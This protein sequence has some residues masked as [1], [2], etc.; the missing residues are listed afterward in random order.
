[1]QTFIFLS[2]QDIFFEVFR[3]NGSHFIRN[4]GEYINLMYPIMARLRILSQKCTNNR[5]YAK[6]EKKEYST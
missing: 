1:M 2:R 4:H 6:Y 5:V 3:K